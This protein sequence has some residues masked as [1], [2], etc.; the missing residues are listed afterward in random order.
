MA[1]LI[2]ISTRAEEY[3][4]ELERFRTGEGFMGCNYIT[5]SLGCFIR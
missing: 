2:K 5:G 3:F 4:L 1:R